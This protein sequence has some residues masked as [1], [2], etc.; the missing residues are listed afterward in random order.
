MLY[1]EISDCRLCEGIRLTTVLDLGIQALTGVFPKPGDEDVPAGPLQL[2]KCED[3]DL[4]QLRHNYDLG[5][6]YGENYG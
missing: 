5:K 1:K 6:L 3:C 4:V 2:C